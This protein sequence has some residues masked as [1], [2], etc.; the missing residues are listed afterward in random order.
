MPSNADR[1]RSGTWLGRLLRGLLW[2]ALSLLS[3][4]CV[5]ALSLDVRHGWARYP[6]AIL[7]V[8]LVAVCIRLIHRPWLRLA[9]CAA[10]AVAVL[11]WWLSLKPSNNRDW[12]PDVSQLASADVHAGDVT[13]HNVRDC[14]YRTELD[15]TCKWETRTYDL[16][17][18]RGAD[19]Y[20]VFWGSPYIAHTMISFQFGA[21]DHVV[22]SIE[23]RKTVGQEYSA[24]LG[25]F[26]QYELIYIVSD[27][28]DVVRLRT[29]YR[30]GAEGQGED[31][32]LYHLTWDPLRARARFLE[33][34]D[35]VNELH[36]QPEWYNALTRNCTTSI[37][38]QRENSPGASIQLSQWNWQVLANGKLDQLVYNHGAY[39]TDGLPFDQLKQ[40]AYINP[41]AREVTGPD[42]PDFS[43]RIRSGRPGFTPAH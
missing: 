23:T 39:V 41:V 18:L 26:R 14:T 29:N 20:F 15:Y 12:Q 6:A 35:R 17:Q 16:S 42:D 25:F 5:M 24:L 22:F 8:A 28:R 21:S 38:E 19:G 4:W 2:F 9:A 31:V 40:R 30:P 10:C 36:A 34:I 11:C 1:S 13:I 43:T 37:F 7:F 3:L 27:E 32:Y 33:Y